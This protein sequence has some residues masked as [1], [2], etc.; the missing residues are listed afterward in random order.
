MYLNQVNSVR[1]MTFLYIVFSNI[2][3]IKGEWGYTVAK[4]DGG[5]P[6]TPM[7]PGAGSRAGDRCWCISYQGIAAL[8]VFGDEN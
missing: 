2:T 3:T 1:S 8:E 5:M 4:Q 7:D 6:W